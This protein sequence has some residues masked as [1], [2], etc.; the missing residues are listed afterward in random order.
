MKKRFLLLSVFILI[1]SLF[2]GC[3]M[4][5]K[6][7]KASFKWKTADVKYENF[8]D[9]GDYVIE[10]DRHDNF[11]FNRAVE[12][13]NAHFDM[14][15]SGGCSALAT[16]T[17]S[18]DVI[19]GRNLDM[20]VSQYPCFISYAEFGKYATVNFTYNDLFADAVKYE[21]L[22]KDG[23]INDD[24]YNVLPLISTDS[25]NSE[26]LYM[27]YNMREFEKQFIC[28]G[29]NPDADIRIC[30]LCLPFVVTSNC[31]TVD[32][33]L[34]YMKE[35]LDIYTLIDDT[36]ASGWNLCFMIGDAKGNYGLIE[37]GNDEIKYLPGQH[38]QA[39]YYIYPE[40]NSTSRNQSGYGRLQFGLERIGKVQNDRDMSELMEQL[41]W[42]N[43]ILNIPYAYRDERGHIHFCED[44]NHK[45]PSLD[46]RSDNVKKLPVNADGKYVDI[47]DASDEAKLVK[48]YKQA[49]E[50]FLEGTDN[51]T[52]RSGFMS[53]SE[54]LDRCD[55]EWVQ[56]NKNFEDLQ[57]GLI[58]HYSENGT[59]EKLKKYYAGDEKELR[60]N[61]CIWTTSLSITANCTKKHITVKFWEKENT[62]MEYQW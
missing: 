15:G 3:S 42:R 48:R 31:A 53:Y 12:Y 28:M 41:M 4:V 11:D 7:G 62:V 17:D 40:F 23:R 9:L 56:T 49:Y 33:A 14:T 25:M 13:A 32:E 43:E 46:W 39:N 27:E 45:I 26:G 47:N 35:K 59:L 55:L 60:D 2:T 51:K 34:E 22:L 61:G 21:D 6:T 30:S 24:Y 57:K 50:Q 54:Y 1:L 18:G 52:T 5:K 10:C 37:I 16:R 58:E 36:V 19:I 29:T 8:T 38:G 44:E 20:T